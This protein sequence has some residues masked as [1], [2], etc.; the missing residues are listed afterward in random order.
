MG[1]ADAAFHESVVPLFGLL[2]GVVS[3]PLRGHPKGGVI[4]G[5]TGGWVAARWRP[6]ICRRPTYLLLI[7]ERCADRSAGPGSLEGS[8]ALGLMLRHAVDHAGAPALT[9]SRG[10]CSYGELAE[11]VAATATGLASLGVEPGD[12]VALRLPNS[13][14]FVVVAL[15]CL[16]IGAP[17]VPL[18]VD[19]PPA[20]LE[21]TVLD[22][23]PSLIVSSE[24]PGDLNPPRLGGR[25]V[26]DPAALL[27]RGGRAPEPAR[28][29][30]RDA[31]LIYTSGT[32]GSPKGIR[33]PERAFR[34]AIA[35]SAG[36]L[37]LDSTTRALCVSPFHFDG[38]YGT[39]FPT[40]VAGGSLVV[41]RREQ[42]L[43]VKPFYTALL[44]EGITHTGFTPSYLRLLL[45]WPSSSRLSASELRTLGLGGE[46]CV[47]ADVARLW[48]LLPDLRVFNRYGPTETTIEVTTHEVEREDV[49]AGTVPIG[50]PHPGVSFHVLDENGRPIPGPDEV[51][52]LYI[53]GSQLMR[54]YWGDDELTARV[55]RDDVVAGTTVYRTGDLVHRDRRGRY[56]YVGRADGVVKR[57]GVRIS[58]HEVARVL[59]GLDGVSEAVCLPTDHD[60]RLGIAGFVEAGPEVTVPALR[61]TAGAQLP[62]TMLP[63][64][65]F[66]VPHLPVGSSGKVDHRR[67][68]EGVGRLPWRHSGATRSAAR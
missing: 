59:R 5:A 30:E 20:R 64:E 34:A 58:L 44:E 50:D 46:E 26:V 22:C 27:R 62:S 56:V 2:V 67:L 28:D 51:G 66:V 25:P 17:F 52:E 40:L 11:R 19:D 43:F 68:L 38:S 63:D 21:R 49:A 45:G 42:L 9:D 33:T 7:V 32:T 48:E 65:L 61:G 1:R 12:R 55:L 36:I 41:P 8:G 39:L 23:D 37:G 47:A 29:P 57:N 6:G 53:G 4:R 31:Y 35:S 14:A 3:T 15:G 24:G 54:G 13:T 16:W 10:S 18:S 60:G